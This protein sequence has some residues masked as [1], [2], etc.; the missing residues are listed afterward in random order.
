M[1]TNYVKKIALLLIPVAG[2]ALAGNVVAKGHGKPGQHEFGMHKE[3]RM[4]MGKLDLTEEQK[5]QIKDIK[6]STKAEMKALK[7]TDQNTNPRGEMSALVLADSFDE[8]AFLALQQKHAAKREQL[9]LIQARSMNQI[10]NVL[11]AE[12]KQEFLQMRAERKQKRMEKRQQRM[13]RKQ[14]S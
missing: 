5:Q 2:L 4:I 10:Y 9:G 6:A 12:Q 14:E 8:G 11:T 3:V 1:T 7:E 13:E